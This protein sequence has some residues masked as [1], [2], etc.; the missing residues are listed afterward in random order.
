VHIKL[1]ELSMEDN[2]LDW[3]IGFPRN[4]IR[5]MDELQN[6]FMEKLR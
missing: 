6:V 2:A 5:N 1:F 4:S 3:F